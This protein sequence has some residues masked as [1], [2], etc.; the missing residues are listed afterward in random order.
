MIGNMSGEKP[1]EASIFSASSKVAAEMGWTV[2][3]CFSVA[4]TYTVVQS[5][6]LPLEG[7]QPV[8]CKYK[9]LTNLSLSFSLSPFSV[10]LSPS[11]PSS[12]SFRASTLM[13]KISPPFRTDTH[14]HTHVPATTQ[15]IELS[16][17]FLLALYI[18]QLMDSSTESCGVTSAV[19][20]WRS[21]M[22]TWSAVIGQSSDHWK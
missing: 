10:S 3:A 20:G 1:V 11:L 8:V 6:L 22:G 4:P 16:H 2:P 18:R 14:T 9:C 21:F 12:L 7:T 5:G 15:V 19:I 17:V 13:N